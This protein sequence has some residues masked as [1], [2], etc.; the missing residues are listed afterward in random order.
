Q[1][2]RQRL[3]VEGTQGFAPAIVFHHHLP[4]GLDSRVARESGLLVRIDES[5][6]E[7]S[8]GTLIRGEEP[9]DRGGNASRLCILFDRI[10]RECERTVHLP[11]QFYRRRTQAVAFV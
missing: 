7:V 1:H 8:F 11:E 2:I 3:L 10:N 5:N 4:A 9:S 6:D